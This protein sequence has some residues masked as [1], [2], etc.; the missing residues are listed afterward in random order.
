MMSYEY[1]SENSVIHLMASGTL[2]PIDPINYFKDID[3]DPNFKPKA[4]ERIY[5]TGLDDIEFKFTDVLMIRDAFERYGHGEKIS[6]GIFIVDSDLSLGMANM[7]ITLFDDVFKN[8][9]IKRTG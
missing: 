4:E 6:H 9:T 2:K 8:F 1:D 7:V 5:F 3:N